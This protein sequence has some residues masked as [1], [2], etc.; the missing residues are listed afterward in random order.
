MR[1]DRHDEQIQ[2]LQSQ[3]GELHETSKRIEEVVM[4]ENRETRAIITTTNTQLMSLI[5]SLMGFKTTNNQ[6]K[7]ESIAKIAALL[8]G[9]G[10][11]LYY[12]FG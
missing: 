2:N 10:G 1:L 3:V 9:S 4:S 6:M 8:T 12:I 5:G 11:I 7:W